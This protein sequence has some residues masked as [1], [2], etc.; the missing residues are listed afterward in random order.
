[1]VS[2]EGCTD[3]DVDEEVKSTRSPEEMACEAE[4]AEAMALSGGVPSLVSSLVSSCSS[5]L[6]AAEVM[7]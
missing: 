2:S 7:E 6:S 3:A 1:M 4:E 5:S